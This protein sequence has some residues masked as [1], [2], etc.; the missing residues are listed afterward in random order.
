MTAPFF[1]EALAV[2]H[3]TSGFNCGV[4][5]LDRYLFQ[6]AGQDVRRRV[7]A[8][9][10]ACETGCS[11]VVG[12]YTLAAACVPLAELPDDLRKR[13]P[14]YPA[15]PVARLGRLAVHRAYQGRHLGAA[16]LWDALMRAVRSEVAVF[17]LI[18]DAKDE[19]AERFYRHHG[20]QPL[21][22]LP[23]RLI[24]SLAR[25]KGNA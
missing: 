13:L 23:G 20:F 8:C 18:V 11:R 19:R 15:V 25:W 10:A 12:Y 1:I 7:T 4:T 17:A 9:Y 14:R 16:L 24:L 6:Q 3:D 21:G 2:H 22:S 5:S